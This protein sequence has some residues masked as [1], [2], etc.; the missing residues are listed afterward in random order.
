MGTEA[1]GNQAYFCCFEKKSACFPRGRELKNKH[2]PMQSDT[3][4]VP[5]LAQ[6]DMLHTP[7]HDDFLRHFVSAEPKLNAYVRAQ[8][9]HR[10]DAEDILQEVSIVLWRKYSQFTPGTSFTAWAFRVAHHEILHCRRKY[11]RSRLEFNESL[12]GQIAKEAESVAN[13]QDIR[14]AAL[15]DCLDKL[16]DSERFLLRQ[17]YWQGVKGRALAQLAAHSESAVGRALRRI[18]ARLLAC[19]HRNLRMQGEAAP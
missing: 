19:I 8:V 17:R 3:A 12:L 1:S 16:P 4:G 9:M 7:D 2:T 18:Q 13:E 11:Q 10:E 14:E 15:A 5:A 6:V